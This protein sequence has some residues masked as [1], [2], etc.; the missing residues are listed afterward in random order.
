M[1]LPNWFKISWW[2]ALSTAVTWF[3]AKRWDDLIAGYAT[4]AD[5]VVFLIWVALLLAPVFQEMEFF[6]LKFKQ[7]VQKLK[8]ELKSEIHS[9][10]AELRNA[11]EYELHLAPRLHGQHPRQMHSC[12]T[13]KNA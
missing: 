2:V 3:L 8:E 4:P 9:V 6:G 12:P 13:W 5:I 10:R 11:V 7:E 1:R